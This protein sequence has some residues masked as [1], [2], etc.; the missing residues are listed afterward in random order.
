V[1]YTTSPL[2]GS[3]EHAR[4]IR[5]EQVRLLYSQA[6]TGIVVNVLVAALAVV[7]LWKDVSTVHLLTWCAAIMIVSAGRM[8]LIR[9]YRRAGPEQ[10]KSSAWE[11]RFITSTVISGTVWGMAGI[12][13]PG[14]GDMQTQI[15]VAFFLGGMVAGAI[16]VLGSMVSAYAAYLLTTMAPLLTWFFLQPAPIYTTMAWMLIVYCAALFV[17][18]RNYHETLCRSLSLAFENGDLTTNLTIANELSSVAASELKSESAQRERAEKLLSTERHI[19]EMIATAVPLE[20]VL[21]ALNRGVE[22]QIEGA[23][24][25]LLLLDE[26]G[27][28]L[29]HGS[30]PNLPQRFNELVDGMSIGPDAGSCGAAA[31][32][33]RQIVTRDI[34]DDPRWSAYREAALAQACVRSCWSTPIRSSTNDVLGTF[35]VYKREPG[36][37]SPWD[38]EVIGRMNQVAGIAIERARVQRVIR[39]SEERFRDLYDDT[40]AMFLT[41]DAKGV[42]LSVNRFGAAELGYSPEELIGR[43]V[44]VLC[45]D[46][47]QQALMEEVRRCFDEV[48]AVHRWHTDAVRK[49]GARLSLR[50][51]ACVQTAAAPRPTLLLVCEDVTE[52]QEL[53]AQLAYQAT[54]DSLTGLVNRREFENRLRQALEAATRDGSEHAFCYLDL[55]QFKVINDTCGHVAGDELLRRLGNLLLDKVRK[56]DTLARL[57]G[58]EFGVL[59]QHCSIDQAERVARVMRTAIEGFQFSWE[60]KTFSLGASIGVVPVVAT[61][62][63]LTGVLKQADAACYAAKESGRNRI[64]VYREEDAKVARRSREI[65]WITRIQQA[66]EENRF[67]LCFQPIV[68]VDPSTSSDGEHFELLLRMQDES[69][70]EIPLGA[71]LPAAE[72]YGLANKLDRWVVREALGWLRD[73]PEQLRQLRIFSINLSGQSIGDKDFLGYVTDCLSETEVPPDSICFEITET[74]AIADL[75]GA[76][77]FIRSLKEKGCRFA[78]DDFGSGLSSFANLKSLDVDYLKIDGFFVKD[79]ARDSISHA[80]VRSINDIGHVLGKRTIAEFVENELVLA[81]LRE[82]GVDFVQGFHLGAPRPLEELSSVSASQPEENTASGSVVRASFR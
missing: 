6:R 53:A 12:L 19:L 69:G 8:L 37:P 75:T 22:E 50:A 25:S 65:Q 61:S 81:K 43:P 59:M 39:E 18:A 57:G 72:R 74:S 67:R 80:M 23:L 41:L 4:T 14:Q 71:F 49:D 5:G 58:D 2:S 70:E 68:A 63:G 27:Q 48:T 7:L 40:P 52:A 20:R 78:L 38:I 47:Y 15:V 30:A 31:F 66:V 36:E 29:R 24:S 60:G 46:G 45:A 1:S 3:Q 42:I 33:G 28:H 82:I 77:Q 54:H 21:D 79:I 55:D 34:S 9:S 26:D 62:E 13:F 32:F 64:H 16:P 56:G 44:S 51:A 10:G 11:A 35:A 76:V 73:H 17:T